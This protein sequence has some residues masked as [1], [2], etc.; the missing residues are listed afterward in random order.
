MDGT[1]PGERHGLGGGRA[2]SGG[3]VRGLCFAVGMSDVIER[4]LT[5]PGRWAV[6]G[7]STNTARPAY[8][9]S[10]YV[11]GL[12]H[13]IVP[14]HPRAETVHGAPGVATLAE[15]EGPV[16]VVDVFVNSRLAGQIADEAIAIGAKAVWF[17]LGVSDDA[18]AARVRAAGLEHVE[19]TCPA[20]EL[21]RLARG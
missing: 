16:D 4:L 13:E 5:A 10:A 11:Q 3:G 14:V 7:L 2:A 20:I 18:A 8:G 15:I 1:E 19:G 17:Q 21:P 6:V 12:G 9:V